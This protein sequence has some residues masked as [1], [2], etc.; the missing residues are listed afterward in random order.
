MKLLDEMRSRVGLVS[1]FLWQSGQ[2]FGD[3]LGNGRWGGQVVTDRA[4]SALIGHPGD[5]DLLA[6]GTD[7][8]GRSFV[9][10]AGL[11]TGSLLGAGFRA[12]RVIRS[13][14]AAS[15]QSMS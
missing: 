3:F 14:V 4:E 12:A 8:V 13:G 15:S 6:F 2:H 5:G 10:V 1:R 7:P 9:G 11:V